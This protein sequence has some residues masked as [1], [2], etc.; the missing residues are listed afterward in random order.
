MPEPDAMQLTLPPRPKLPPGA[1]SALAA[2]SC[3]V[4][5]A[6]CGI[7]EGGAVELVASDFG[8]D[9]YRKPGRVRTR[10]DWE[11][12]GSRLPLKTLRQTLRCFSRLTGLKR[13]PQFSQI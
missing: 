6:N 10:W 5:V 1:T 3:A 11:L 8:L 9:G 13:R 12:K 7:E 2:S 4:S